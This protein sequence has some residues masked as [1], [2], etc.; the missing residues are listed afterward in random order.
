MFY[1][2]VYNVAFTAR[3]GGTIKYFLPSPP[4]THRHVTNSDV[5]SGRPLTISKMLSLTKANEAFSLTFLHIYFSSMHFYRRHN[6]D[7]LNF[8]SVRPDSQHTQ[9][10]NCNSA[11][12]HI[13]SRYFLIVFP[14]YSIVSTYLCLL[15]LD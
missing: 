14:P 4:I 13:L 3:C 7:G 15:A 2:M 10:A 11:Y 9:R 1:D 5:T 8:H 12:F 6:F